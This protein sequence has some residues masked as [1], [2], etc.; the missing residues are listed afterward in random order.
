MKNVDLKTFGSLLLNHIQT[1]GCLPELV[2]NQQTTLSLIMKA[3]QE[4]TVDNRETDEEAAVWS[5]IE[6]FVKALGEAFFAEQAEETLE[7]MVAAFESKI[8]EAFDDLKIIRD[9][10]DAL[11]QLID[12]SI[13]GMIAQDPF[14]STNMN[15]VHVAEPEYV[16]VPWVNIYTVNNSEETIVTTVNDMVP[17]YAGRTETSP[18][19]MAAVRT[20]FVEQITGNCTDVDLGQETIDRILQELSEKHSGPA[21][22]YRPYLMALT[23]ARKGETFFADRA[24][25]FSNMINPV[26]TITEAFALLTPLKQTI[27]QLNETV[28][29]SQS[30]NQMLNNIAFANRLLMMAAYYLIHCRRV[31]YVNTILL[32]TGQLNADVLDAFREKGGS[33]LKLA[34]HVKFFY[35]ED[36]LAKTAGGVTVDA[37]IDSES[38]IKE[39][40]E[41]DTRDVK[42]RVQTE[43]QRIASSAYARIFRRYVAEQQAMESPVEPLID[44]GRVADLIVISAESLPKTTVEDALYDLLMKVYYTDKFVVVLHRRLG[45][46]MTKELAL[47]SDVDENQIRLI[48]AR[49]L[50]AMITEFIMNADLISVVG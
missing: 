25:R 36:K 23:I 7:G 44:K 9:T 47:A 31:A 24:R 37:V 48:E 32:P 33:L 49:V 39:R 30:K 22:A 2:V 34:Q 19:I 21:E 14:L 16:R 12:N 4:R 46:E 20:Q 10:V 40:V 41:K 45:A 11:T 42:L 13:A 3:L 26:E 18:E 38:V 35:P 50:T 17:R 5:V 43:L 28:L 29:S 6:D 8:R 27:D 1:R 15:T